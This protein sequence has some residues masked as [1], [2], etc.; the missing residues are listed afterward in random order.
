[1]STAL[2]GD[3]QVRCLVHGPVRWRPGAGWRECA[4]FDGEGRGECGVFLVYIED[5]E[6]AIRFGGGI[7]G[8]EVAVAGGLWHDTRAWELPQVGDGL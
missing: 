2:P 5:A 4:G 8:V 3:V 7:P 6:A 1:M